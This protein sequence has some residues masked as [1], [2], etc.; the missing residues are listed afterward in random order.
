VLLL[1]E[2]ALGSTDARFL[3]LLAAAREDMK[4]PWKSRGLDRRT[5]ETAMQRPIPPEVDQALVISAH[6]TKILSEGTRD[7]LREVLG[8]WIA[9][10]EGAKFWLSVMNEL[11]E[12]GSRD[13]ISSTTWW[14]FSGRGMRASAVPVAEEKVRPHPRQRRR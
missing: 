3:R 9:D 11:H 8:L 2:N 14:N 1:A 13:N 6:V 7:G 10:N 4:R 12:P 5:V